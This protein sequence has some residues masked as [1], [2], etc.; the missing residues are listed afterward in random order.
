[1]DS[2]ISS[3]VLSK[4]ASSLSNRWSRFLKKVTF[5]LCYKT[6]MLPCLPC[7]VCKETGHC[8]TKCP[9][10][11][12]ATNEPNPPQPTGPRGQDEED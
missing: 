9:E 6:V 5:G 1:M 3:I 10:L 2:S 4:Q 8:A 7:S 11:W 12:S